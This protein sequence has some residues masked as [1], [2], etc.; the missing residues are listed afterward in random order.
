MRLCYRSWLWLWLLPLIVGPA[1]QPCLRIKT[2][3]DVG[4]TVALRRLHRRR[5]ARHLHTRI[6]A[7][8]GR[9]RSTGQVILWR[10]IAVKNWLIGLLRRR[11]VGRIITLLNTLGRLIWVSRC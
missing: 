1:A 5:G 3:P 10:C 6:V 11:L 4:L 8:L 2:S 9:I 7:A